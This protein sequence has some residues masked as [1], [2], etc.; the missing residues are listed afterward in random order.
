MK[1][2]ERLEL[3]PVRN[4]LDAEGGR[5]RSLIVDREGAVE[6]VG[7]YYFPQ[8]VISA[9]FKTENYCLS[10]MIENDENS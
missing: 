3:I 10:L 5:R 9:G 2:K 4:I 1:S 6:E 7:S 8:G